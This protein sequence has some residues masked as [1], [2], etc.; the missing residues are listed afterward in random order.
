MFDQFIILTKCHLQGI[1]RD[2]VLYGV[3]GVSV[4]MI[5]M[6]PSMS[7][8][9]MRQ[10]QE[11]SITLSLSVISG[12]LLVTT[13]LLGASSVWRD[14]E[15]RYL[16]SIL[17]LPISRA[18][19]LVSK[20]CSILLFLTLSTMVL[21]MGCAVAIKL[22]SSSYP[23]DIPIHWGNI[24]LTIGGDLF[25]YMLLTAFSLLLSS[26]STSFYLPFFG[27]LVIYFCGSASQEVYEYVTGEFGSG[28]SLMA[29]SAVKGAYYLL[30]NFAAFDFHV[31]AVYGLPVS[32]TGLSL[33]MLYTL[34]YT[35]ILLL[36]A[37]VN[38]ERRELP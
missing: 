19:F 1:L 36:L 32:L 22:A 18:T 7:S 5:L 17:T 3:L 30:P 14:I 20:F 6:I 35:G 8:F 16:H 13:L 25:K 11:L 10:V 12:T 37:V 34:V 28:M 4:F 23:S 27:T 38:F 31:H 15:R 26:L 29:I 24:L 33:T 9:S 21:G 2:R